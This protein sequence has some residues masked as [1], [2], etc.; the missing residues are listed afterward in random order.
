MA[1]VT[2]DL[3]WLHFLC[4]ELGVDVST[5]HY[6]WC[7]NISVVALS[8]NPVFHARTKHIEVDVHFVREKVF[9]KFLDVGHAKSLLAA[10]F[11]GLCE[12]LCLHD[13]GD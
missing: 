10:R 2:S 11:H 8:S 6:L 9:S 3:L 1:K 7:D 5:P 13:V 4:T 12:K